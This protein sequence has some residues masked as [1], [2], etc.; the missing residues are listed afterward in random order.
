MSELNDF[1]FSEHPFALVPSS[2]VTNWAGRDDERRLL[3]D[4]VESVLTT[5][6]GLSEFVLVHGKLRRGKVPRAEIPR[7]SHFRN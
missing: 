2:G 3:R 7:N 1:G 5:D 6:T 4:I